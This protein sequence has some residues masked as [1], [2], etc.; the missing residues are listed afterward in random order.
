MPRSTSYN[1]VA[2]PIALAAERP[3]VYLGGAN[4]IPVIANVPRVLV[5]HDCLAFRFPSA[6][7]ARITRYLQRWMR[8]S[9]EHADRII[10]I[11]RW[12]AL[13]AGRY[14]GANTST[15]S[16]VYQGVDPRFSP[17]GTATLPDDR[18]RGPYVLQVG[19]FEP[20]K[21]TETAVAAINELRARGRDVMLVRTGG[22]ATAAG[23]AVLDLGVVDDPTLV[24]LYRSARAVCVPSDH[25]GF[26]LPV[27]E[28][29]ACGTPVVASNAAGLP[30]AGG[31]V[32]LY[33]DPGDAPGFA[34]AIERLL[35]DDAER[36]RRREAGIARARTFTWADAAAR[37]LEICADAARAR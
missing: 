17:D 5:I 22:Q 21:G 24:S 34:N 4:I 19:A 27:L 29:M 23:D 30:E 32:A 18:I 7:P 15:V 8:R 12:A 31:D 26:G 37:V 3:D 6:K 1:Q 33:A 14:L 35:V 20:H 28:A 16:V 36:A 9:A 2:L 11:S 10:A 13:E 25:E